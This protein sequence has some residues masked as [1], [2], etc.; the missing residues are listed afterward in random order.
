MKMPSPFQF[1]FRSSALFGAT[2]LAVS[3]CSLTAPAAPTGRIHR[4]SSPEALPS[5]L[6]PSDWGSIVQH[7][8]V[9]QQAYLK[10]ANTGVDDQ[11]G[12]SVAVSGDTAVVGAW[13]EDSAATSVNGI[14]PHAGAAYVFVRSGTTWSLQARLAASNTDAVDQFGLSVAV[15]DDTV[16]VGAN[17]EDSAATG[18]N[19]NQSDNSCTNS[20]AA[21]VFVRT[22]TTWTQQAYLKA[23]N[24][25]ASDLFGGAVAVSGDTVVVGAYGESSSA[26]GVNGRQDDNSAPFSGAAYVFVRNGTA[27]TQQGYLK[28]SN[29]EAHDQFGYSV[30]VSGDTVVV[31]AQAE[32]SKATGVNGDQSDNS[33]PIAGA[34]YVFVRNGTT[35]TQQAYLKA[36]NTDTNDRFGGS[37]AVSGD[38]V[39][40]G[41]HYEDSAATGVDGDQ[42][43][44]S[45]PYSGAAYVFVRHGTVWTQQAHLK[46][47]NTGAGDDFGR[48]VAVSGNTVVVGAWREDSHATG[49]NGDQSDQSATNSGAAYVFVRRGMTWSQQ[50]YLK[51]SNTEARDLFG[52]SV[53]VSGDTAVVGAFGE[54][55]AGTGVNGNPNDN[56][57]PTSGA[58]Y[59]F[60]GL[61]PPPDADGDGVPDAED[62]CPDTLPGAV[63]DAAG[64]SIEQLVPCDGPWRNHGEYVR[65][66]YAVT[67]HFVTEGLLT[68]EQGRAM[69]LQGVRSDCGRQ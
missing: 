16:V 4:F 52:F 24:P 19:G 64:C 50:A 60:T 37:V 42:D 12:Y 31:G 47:S 28:A 5:G 21:Y 66:L 45:A 7:M 67:S 6:N 27:W 58:A 53:A 43:D 2:L 54:D 48:S 34:A 39:V 22:G 62:E 8:P 56:G 59:V 23:T 38:T 46:A 69:F 65:A 25:D 51:A 32:A 36:S 61:G 17:A 13:W 14:A 35:W 33:V 10:A 20:G 15:W 44:K 11:F 29:T 63:T 18:V 3:W 9:T 30:A 49:V 57:A 26:T 41:A 1:F 55:S 40:V 68:R